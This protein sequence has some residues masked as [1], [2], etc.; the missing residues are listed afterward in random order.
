MSFTC[1][2]FALLKLAGALLPADG[3]A[4]LVLLMVL[5]TYI[6]LRLG[7]GRRRN[8]KQSA[9]PGER[10]SFKT[11]RSSLSSNCSTQLLRNYA[12]LVGGITVH[13][14]ACSLHLA[15][16]VLLKGRLTTHFSLLGLMIN[17]FRLSCKGL[18]TTHLART[19]ACCHY[20]ALLGML[21]GRTLQHCSPAI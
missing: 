11:R 20:V 15:K 10:G 13:H 7:F 5:P 2:A 19:C 6:L 4:D 3:N 17:A 16:A 1:R 21:Y 9:C 8:R 14:I 12:V 18:Q